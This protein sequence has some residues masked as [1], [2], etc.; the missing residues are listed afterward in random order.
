MTDKASPEKGGKFGYV[1]C[2]PK[3]RGAQ[4]KLSIREPVHVVEETFATL[5]HFSTPATCLLVPPEWTVLVGA[6]L[7]C[8]CVP[9]PISEH[10]PVSGGAATMTGTLPAFRKC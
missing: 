7:W 9:V 10:V 1:L 4:I 5:Y 2:Y 8:D 6:Q 3:S